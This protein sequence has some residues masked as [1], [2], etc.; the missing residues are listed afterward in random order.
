MG[1]WKPLLFFSKT[2]IRAN[3]MSAMETLE[4]EANK[5]PADF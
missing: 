3:A 1:T 5:E 2:S 4:T